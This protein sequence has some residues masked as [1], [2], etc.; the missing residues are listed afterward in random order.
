VLG[1]ARVATDQLR[2]GKNDPS[3]GASAAPTAPVAPASQL[4][5][6]CSKAKVTLLDVADAGNHV[7]LYGAADKKYVGHRVRIVFTGTG[8][9][10]ATTTVRR[11]GFF[12]T[13]APVPSKGI[14]YTSR[15]RYMAIVGRD[16]SMPLK[17]HR[18]MRITS[19]HHHGRTIRLTGRIYGPAG[20]QPITISRRISCTKD[21]VVGHVHP[22]AGGVW[23]ATVKAP[24]GTSAAVY[25]ADTIVP[26][27]AGSGKMFPTF[28]LPGYVSL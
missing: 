14:R 2:C 25:R 16:K 12:R 24:R 19:M 4:A 18:R 11:D 15:A 22:G 6:S 1:I 26:A 3:V 10:V 20:N 7:G 23:H 9:Q 5:V 13:H 21:V 17:L 28:T 8:K 27:S